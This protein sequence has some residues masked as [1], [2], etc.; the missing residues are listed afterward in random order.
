MT[1]IYDGNVNYLKNI[2]SHPQ[3]INGKDS[4]G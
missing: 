2:R 4:N 3:S 1:I